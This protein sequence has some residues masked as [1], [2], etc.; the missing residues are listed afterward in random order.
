MANNGYDIGGICGLCKPRY[1]VISSILGENYNPKNGIDVFIDLNTLITALSTSRKFMNSLPFSENVEENV[2]A[3]ILFIVKHW[4]DYLRK[5]DNYRTFLIVND[6]DMA[7]LAEQEHLNSYLIPHVHKYEADR[8]KQFVYYLSESYKRIEI[9]LKYIPNSYMIRCKRFD[10][11]MVPN[12]IDDY[13]KNGRD[14][15]I[16][17]NNSMMTNYIYMPRTKVI[18]TRYKHTGMCQISDPLMIVQSLTKIDEEI[19]NTFVKNKVFYNLMN[20]IIGDFDRGIIGINQVGISKFASTLLRSVERR[21]IPENPK[22]FE[23]VLGIV[24]KSYHDYIRQT[25]PL[26]DIESHSRMIP[27]S[28]I[29]KVKSEMVD[30]YD[31]DGL[32]SFT[33]EGLNLLELM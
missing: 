25:Y 27:Y 22:S 6:F 14:R 21:E 2:I 11:Y 4:R 12:I 33:I 18:Y 19:M 8:Y 15:V 31:I 10:S 23:S 24:D 30:L 29:E 9:V 26:V 3:S 32:R 16:L 13:D 7:M 28:M 1:K 5:W 17:T 20:D